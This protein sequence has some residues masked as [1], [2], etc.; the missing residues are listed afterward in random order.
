LGLVAFQLTYKLWIS[1]GHE[2]GSVSNQIFAVGFILY[3]LQNSGAKESRSWHPHFCHC[4]C[5]DVLLPTLYLQIRNN[6]KVWHHANAA[7]SLLPLI[8][9]GWL[10]LYPSRYHRCWWVDGSMRAWEIYHHSGHHGSDQMQFL[11]AQIRS[12]SHRVSTCF[13]SSIMTDV[14]CNKLQNLLASTNLL[15]SWGEP[16]DA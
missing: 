1:P 10:G 2:V 8:I 13:A 15:D 4:K 16:R 5:H 12:W 14:H 9:S 3:W 11:Y 6:V 7:V